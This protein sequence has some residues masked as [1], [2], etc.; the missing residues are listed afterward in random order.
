MPVVLPVPFCAEEMTAR[1]RLVEQIVL[2]S[3][4]ET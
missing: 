1:G 2:E 3:E 4:L